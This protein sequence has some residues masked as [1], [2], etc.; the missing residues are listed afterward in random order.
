MQRLNKYAA[1]AASLTL[2][3]S[4]VGCETKLRKEGVPAN[5]TTNQ[6][7]QIRTTNCFNTQLGL[8]FSNDT[9]VVHVRLKAVPQKGNDC[10][11]YLING[12]TDD[13]WWYQWGL[14]YI[15]RADGGDNFY[16]QREVWDPTGASNRMWSVKSDAFP[17]NTDDILELKLCI[18]DGVLHMSAA[19]I[20]SKL[21]IDLPSKTE[22]KTFVGGIENRSGE[23]GV[24]SVMTEVWSYSENGA[25]NEQNYDVI[26]PK[27]PDLPV[28]T[29]VIRR[30]Y[31]KEIGKVSEEGT[32]IDLLMAT[33]SEWYTPKQRTFTTSFLTDN[34]PEK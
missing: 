33:R 30:K 24:T 32:K 1:Y 26:L 22:A 6:V 20:N 10:T 4:L 2:A 21:K 3:A 31:D 25:I 29:F 28:C 13:N 34:D 15:K 23:M 8:V 19:N 12:K 16:L 14:V 11:A 27:L 7:E 18:K 9:T 17:I 5:P